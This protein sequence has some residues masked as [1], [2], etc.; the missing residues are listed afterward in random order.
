M[1]EV[2]SDRRYA[3]LFG[4]QVVALLGTGLLTVGLALAAY[5]LAGAQAS[6]VLGVALTIKMVAYVGFS[7]IA[8]ALI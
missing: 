4:A 2:L 5:D 6:I 1:L 3:R 8:S 7:P